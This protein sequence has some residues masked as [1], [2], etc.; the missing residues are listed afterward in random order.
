MSTP[1]SIVPEN[2]SNAVQ[3][4]PEQQ[5]I[6]TDTAETPVNLD[7]VVV[8]SS[9]DRTSV[10]RFMAENRIGFARS[11]RFY[12]QITSAPGI[13]Q[14]PREFAFMCESAE[15]PC[16]ELTTVDTRVYGPVYKSPNLSAYNDVNFTVLCDY[17][18]SEKR[19]FD[20]WVDYIN[21]TS[22]YNFA[23]RDDYVTD[24]AIFHLNE[25][26]DV[27]YGI[28]LKEAFP[29]SVGSLQASWGDDNIHRLQV[30]ITYRYWEQFVDPPNFD[31]S[32]YEESRA[33]HESRV[34]F[35]SF[36]SGY[37]SPVTDA[38]G[39]RRRI[40]RTLE[41]STNKF[42]KVIAELTSG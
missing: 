31:I 9:N 20:A 12:V 19:F 7:Q 21:P 8:T 23:F 17:Q 30:G 42:R 38:E 4:S 25:S 5:Q 10:S 36:E 3:G 16:R 32:I 11:N 18:M 6:A 13:E 24:I 27:T 26:N 22:N 14:L 29:V 15:F 41:E 34:Q 40:N 33:A 28:R 39:H 1:I 2:N 35:K 37:G